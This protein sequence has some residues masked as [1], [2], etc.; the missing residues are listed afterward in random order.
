VVVG[1]EAWSNDGAAPVDQAPALCRRHR[2]AGAVYFAV[3]YALGMRY[4]DLRRGR[5]E[6]RLN[7]AA[8]H[9]RGAGRPCVLTIGAFDGLHAG[10]R[11]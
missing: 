11:R 2:A 1:P 10:I 6:L 9:T 8:C 3:L 5:H 7:Y 4:R